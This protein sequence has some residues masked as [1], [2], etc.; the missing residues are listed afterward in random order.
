MPVWGDQ[1]KLELLL[2]ALVDNE[3]K[4]NRKGG[5]LSIKAEYMTLHNNSMVYQQIF[6][7]GQTVQHGRTEDIFQGYSKLG[8][9]DADKPSGIGI[10]LATAGRSCARCGERFI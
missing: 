8:S 6:N 9:L 1:D 10:G 7:Q 5:L 3:V 4:F 2:D